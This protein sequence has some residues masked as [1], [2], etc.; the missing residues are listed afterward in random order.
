MPITI[1]S[2]GTLSS[3]PRAAIVPAM[4]PLAVSGVAIIAAG[5]AAAVLLI[6]WLLRLEN[7][8]DELEGDEPPSPAGPDGRTR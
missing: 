5:I 8:Y 3:P 7:R 6:I 4:V 1:Q 2:E